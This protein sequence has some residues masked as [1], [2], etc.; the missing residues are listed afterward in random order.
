[1]NILTHTLPLLSGTFGIRTKLALYPKMS[2]EPSSP[3]RSNAR[4]ER[5]YIKYEI[6]RLENN[7]GKRTTWAS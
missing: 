1:M 2:K 6:N 3:S 5:Q 4:I 7:N